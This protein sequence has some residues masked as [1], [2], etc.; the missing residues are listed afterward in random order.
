MFNKIKEYYEVKKQHR[1]DTYKRMLNIILLNVESLAYE[2]KTKYLYE[3]PEHVL[4]EPAYDIQECGEYLV[5]KLKG[6]KF[7]DVSF[8]KPNVIYLEWEIK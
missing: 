1:K 4:G 3:I 7:K 8:Y 6:Y 2:E 5:D